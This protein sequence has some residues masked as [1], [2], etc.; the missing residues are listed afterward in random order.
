MNAPVSS[1]GAVRLM[2]VGDLILGE[3]D[4]RSYVEPGRR[5]LH[6]ADLVVG[7]VEIPHTRR[8]SRQ[9]TSVPAVPAPPESLA[10]LRWAGFHVGTLAGNHVFDAGPE[11]VV[12]TRANLVAN[13]IAAVGAGRDL[14]E[15]RRPAIVESAGRRWAVLAYNCVG[16]ELSWAGT[17]KAG[18]AYV[19][20]RTPDG[21]LADDPGSPA[22]G[23]RTLRPDADDIAAMAADIAAVRDDVDFVVV[24]LHKGVV[25]TRA[26]VLPYETQVA[27]AAI[28]AG[29]DAVAAHHAHILRGIELYR[30]KPVFHGLGNWVTVTRALTPGEQDD[31]DREAWAHKRLEL[32]GFTPD[33]AMPAY[34]FHPESRH[35]MVGVVDL[36]P[37][38][39]LHAGFVP[40]WIDDQARPVPCDPGDGRGADVVSYV[41]A[42]TE[43]AGF[44]TSF[45]VQPG[46]PVVRAHI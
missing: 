43:E 1:A 2:V 8:G 14:L 33:P 46:N 29:A 30:G 9:R 13:Q 44:R 41:R 25:H 40:C 22:S 12:D 17:D 19:G 27:H 24:G 21:Q 11:G 15:A 10:A 6:S 26:A 5:L 45:T 16:P 23:A 4:P 31:A 35:T 28:D 34:P 18:C 36:G 7:N 39:S 3:P 38:G 20:L 32:F 42:I 37:D